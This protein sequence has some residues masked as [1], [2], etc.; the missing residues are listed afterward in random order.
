MTRLRLQITGIIG[1]PIAHS[2]S[3]AMHNASF[4]KKQ[5]P[6]VYLPFR[7]RPR[8]LRRFL[9]DIRSWGWGRVRGFNV[10]I[11][12]KEA[13]L[14][15]LDRVSP[16]ARAIGAVNT[17]VIEKGKFLGY[18]TD[19]AGWLRSLEDETGL[20]PKGKT[21]VVLGAGGAAR[22][23]VYALA[24]V[25]TREIAV[26]NRTRS[27]A[28]ALAREFGKK[29]PHTRIVA[30]PFLSDLLH[31]IFSE[32]DLLVNTTSVGLGGTRFAGLSLAS[33]NKKAVVSDLVY[34]PLLTPLLRQA[35]KMRLKIHLGW[36]MLLHQGALSAR[37]WTKK[38]PD[39]R[40]M[41]DA[42]LNGLRLDGLRRT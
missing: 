19:A 8:E 1:D 28:D 13:I 40:A 38:N 16:E 34:R 5:L 30:V 7:V 39:V 2:L 4:R 20:R 23:V 9:K 41:R 36:G 37:L 26:S 12:H 35:K 31:K 6:Y 32:I 29:F 15:F 42:L 21:A 33:L 18:N 25:G 17:V 3:P 10:T 11:P 24:K 14:P 27:R 22:A